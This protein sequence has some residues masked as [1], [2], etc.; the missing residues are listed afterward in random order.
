MTQRDLCE[1]HHAK[2]KSCCKRGS[3]LPEL[4]AG[5]KDTLTE[6][7][8]HVVIRLSSLQCR[9][10]RTRGHVGSLIPESQDH[11]TA[12]HHFPTGTDNVTRRVVHVGVVR[13]RLL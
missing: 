1:E 12:K 4:L 10:V 9:E 11:Q 8:K 3:V 5:M 2:V 7:T 13:R 6:T